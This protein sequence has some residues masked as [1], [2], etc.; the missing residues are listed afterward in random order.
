MIKTFPIRV[1]DRFHKAL[2]QAAH[3]ANK[4]IHQYIIDSIKEQMITDSTDGKLPF[5][6]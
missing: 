6:E 4:S 2:K 3:K 5:E 1:T